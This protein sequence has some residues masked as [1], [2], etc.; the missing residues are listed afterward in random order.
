[1]EFPRADGPSLLAWVRIAPELDE[2]TCRVGAAALEILALQ[3]GSVAEL[4]R[5]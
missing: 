2:E 5:A 3:A 4:R 1:V